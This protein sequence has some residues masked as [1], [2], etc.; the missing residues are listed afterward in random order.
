MVRFFSAYISSAT[1]EFTHLSTTTKCD[2]LKST[3]ELGTVFEKK[4][5]LNK[6]FQN[7]LLKFYKLGESLKNTT[8]FML[9]NYVC[10]AVLMIL[11]NQTIN[12][13]TTLGAWAAVD[14]ET[15]LEKSHVLIYE[16][17]GKQFGRI[18]RLLQAPNHLCDKCSDHR[19]NQPILNMVIIEN[20]ELKDNYWQGGKVLYPRQGKWYPL[21]YWL[22]G[23]DP[24]TLVLRGSW[25]MLYRTQYW[26]RVK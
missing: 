2:V 21:K 14:D 24:D 25:G 10:A 13:Q 3:Q 16:Q 15:G 4:L 26:T 6:V 20:M 1:A 17:D 12:A 18:V 8:R 19:K 5:S 9:L 22:K 11:L 23:D 7:Y